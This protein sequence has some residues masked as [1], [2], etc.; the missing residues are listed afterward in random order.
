M[1]KTAKPTLSQDYIAGVALSV[2]DSMGLGKFS[3][4]K[5]GA[6]I[7]VDP[8]AVYY[9]FEDQEALFDAVAELLFD[10]FDVDSL[11]WRGSWRALLERSYG[12]MRDTLVAHPHAVPVFASRPIRSAKAIATGNQTLASLREAGFAPEV[13]L[14]MTRSL[15][16][17]TIGHAMG[18]AAVQLGARRRSRKPE[19]GAP[20]YDLLAESADAVG[21]DQHF[22]LGLTAMLDGF[23]RLKS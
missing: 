8:M 9:Y 19:P 18:L 13:A 14:Q 3:M 6:E 22:D 1:S 12:R 15:R 5:L 10:E 21:I 11:P 7:G 20:G 23:D 17:Y 2:I 16:D 4:R